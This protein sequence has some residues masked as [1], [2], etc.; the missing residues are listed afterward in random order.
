MA[1]TTSN[2]SQAAG[3]KDASTGKQPIA[4]RA[5]DGGIDIIHRVPNGY[6]IQG[7]M[8]VALLALSAE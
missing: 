1:D 6:G 5:K 4:R 2:G 7:I 8:G 3:T